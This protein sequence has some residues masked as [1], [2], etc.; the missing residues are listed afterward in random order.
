MYPYFISNKNEMEIFLNL[1]SLID[2]IIVDILR[3]IRSYQYMIYNIFE[4]FF[5]PLHS[6]ILPKNLN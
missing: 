1:I 4:I 3:N 5:C 2:E 6:I